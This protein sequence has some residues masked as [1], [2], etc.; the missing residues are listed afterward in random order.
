[1]LFLRLDVIVLVL[2]SVGF[3]TLLERKVLG[4]IHLRK[5]P[6]KVGV[7]G[8]LQPLRDGVKLIFKEVI[9]IHNSNYYYYLVRPGLRM[10]LMFILWLMLPFYENYL[11]TSIH[12][13]MILCIIS[14]GVYGLIL[15]GW[16]SNS[17]YA[18]LGGLR[19]VAQTVSYEASII[20][21]IYRVLL[22]ME[23]FRLIVCQEIQ[24][25]CWFIM[26]LYPVGFILY[27]RFLAELNR[28]PF[29]FSE[30]ESELVSGFN[31]EY[32]G[33]PFALFII[34]EYG[35]ILFII[36]LF[37]VLI[38]G[39]N[40]NSVVF[41]LI[42][43]CIVFRVLWCRGTFPRMRYDE[44]IYLTWKRFLPRILIILIILFTVKIIIFYI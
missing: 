36:Y 8:L 21:I 42:Y 15:S 13:V 10:V 14:I 16:A 4:Y 25:Y 44:I 17:T 20:F 5:G 28:T 18:I 7:Y 29:D 31:V 6:N 11:C 32:V 19:S 12:V 30:G 37:R 40:L 26:L 38:L 9:Y 34:A 23:R 33:A 27:V 39:G 43:I 22:I 3:L 35:I 2:I 41:Y 24:Y 1:M